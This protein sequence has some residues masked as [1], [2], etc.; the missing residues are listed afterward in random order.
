[1]ARRLR[2]LILLI[3]FLRYSWRTPGLDLSDSFKDINGSPRSEGRAIAGDSG[4][5]PISRP[6]ATGPAEGAHRPAGG[7]ARPPP[8]LP[9]L[10]LPP[11]ISSG[12]CRG[13]RL[14]V[15]LPQAPADPLNWPWQA[16]IKKKA[17]GHS[18]SV[19]A[20]GINAGKAGR[21]DV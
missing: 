16:I 12:L 19:G 5:D 2:G 11:L 14:L 8:S 18:R 6:Q 3:E 15:S 7:A 10:L 4:A 1:M 9:A 21:G 20:A 17:S 13:P